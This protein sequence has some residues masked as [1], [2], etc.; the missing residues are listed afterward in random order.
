MTI[1][2]VL[3]F[4]IYHR[5]RHG[6][7]ADGRTLKEN[8]LEAFEQAA[9]EN[10]RMVELDVWDELRV[11]HDPEINSTAPRL[12]EV[13]DILKGRCAV[14]VEIK[15][16]RALPAAVHCITSALDSSS[17]QAD[18][19]VVSAFHHQTAIDC[20]RAAPF[21]RVG[22]I[23]DGVLLPHYIEHLH[24]LGIQNLHLDWANIYMDRES[25][26]AMR[27]TIRKLN[28]QIWTWTVN[29]L[30]AFKIVSDYGVEAVFTDNPDLFA[31]KV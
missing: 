31:P 26:F 19:F 24:S 18:Q 28:M 14:N 16:P 15:S 20:K 22:A 29:S 12:P 3:P 21:L 30:P 10:A 17:W 8:S 1:N 11:Q 5:G 23:N 25:G 27:D 9:K 7:L 2:K 13:L 4:L 6:T